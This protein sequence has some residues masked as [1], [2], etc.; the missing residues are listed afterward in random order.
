M[1]PLVVAQAM[2]INTNPNRNRTMDPEMVLCNSL[3]IRCHLDTG[4]K[5]MELRLSWLSGTWPLNTNMAP[6]ISSTNPDIPMAIN[7]NR[8]LGHQRRYWQPQ[9][10]RPTYGLTTART[11]LSSWSWPLIGPIGCHALGGSTCR[12]GLGHQHDQR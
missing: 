5:C 8:S 4:L 1:S 12:S 2:T 3:E 6:G 9:G 10:H 7:G 11:H